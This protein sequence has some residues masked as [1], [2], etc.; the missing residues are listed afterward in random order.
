MGKFCEKNK[1]RTLAEETNYQ[2]V[3]IE[4]L[5]ERFFMI[6]FDVNG[7]KYINEFKG[8]RKQQ[9]RLRCIADYTKSNEATYGKLKCIL[10]SKSTKSE[11][12]QLE[13]RAKKSY[14]AGK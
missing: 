1:Q 7:D 13:P 4:I 5:L 10:V 9:T 8:A 11:I 6:E 3:G 2:V 12:A 14:Q